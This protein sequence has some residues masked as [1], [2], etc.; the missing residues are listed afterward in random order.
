VATEIVTRWHLEMSGP[1]RLVPALPPAPGLEVRQAEIPSPELARFLYMA[2]GGPWY[3]LDRRDW[4]RE[5][6][7][8]RLEQPGVETWVAYLR[9]TPAGYAELAHADATVEL[10]YFGL[11]PDFIGRGLGPRV[12]HAVTARAWALGPER[13]TV[14]TC[15]LDGPAALRTYERAGFEI[16]HRRD[17]RVALPDELPGAW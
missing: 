6:W 3:W 8:T 9:G 2:V 14:D 4:D 11:L 17:D 10:A 1:E 7:R 13:V 15:S 16:H 12:L 5:R